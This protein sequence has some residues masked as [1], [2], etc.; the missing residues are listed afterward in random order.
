MTKTHRFLLHLGLGLAAFIGAS[1]IIF[2]SLIL[3]S[4][5]EWHIISIAG[6]DGTVSTTPPLDSTIPVLPTDPAPPEPTPSAPISTFIDLQPIVDQWVATYQLEARAGVMVYDLDYS[7]TA[8]SFHADEV[9][10][11]ASLYKLLFAYDGYRQIALGLTDPDAFYTSTSTKGRL[12][13]SQCLDLMIR[14]S[15]NGCADKIASDRTN[16]A[17]VANLMQELGMTNTS[18]LGLQSTAADLTLLLRAYYRHSELTDDL[19]APLANSMLHQ[20]PAAGDSGEI[21]DWRQGLPAGFSDH[22]KV[23]NKVGWEWNGSS[24]NIYTDAAILDFVDLDRHYTVVVI[25]RNLSDYT[26]ITQLGRMLED[27][28]TLSSIDIIK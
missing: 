23:Y 21:Y 12:T 19:W 13:Y 11:V 1:I 16:V 25:T 14:E 26:I 2:G 17:R 27:A 7:R 10:N 9:F 5:I 24:W 3:R 15:Y 22:V 4:Y 8:A 28:I 20:P 6:S 18:N